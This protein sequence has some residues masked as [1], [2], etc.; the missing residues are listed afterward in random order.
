MDTPLP[1]LPT[2]VV[3]S[4]ARPAWHVVA[5]QHMLAGE[6]GPIDIQ[7]TEDGAVDAAILAQE[8]AGI[9]V[10]TDGEMRRPAGYYRGFYDQFPVRELPPLRR[11]GV[12][13]YDTRPRYELTGRIEPPPH[14]LGL[15]AA[16]EYLRA[17][18]QKPLKATVPG[19]ATFASPLELNGFYAD[20]HAL[21]Y[22]W[23]G[24]I[25]TELRALQAAGATFI[26]L[27]DPA[28]WRVA[29]ESATDAVAVFNRC[30]EGITVKKALH[31]CFGTYQGK[32]GQMR[33]YVPMF[34]AVLDVNVDQLVLEFANREMSE[35]ELWRDFAVEKELGAGVIDCKCYEVETPEDV[36]ARIRRLLA[37]CPPERLWLNPDCGFRGTTGFRT[38]N[39]KLRA[40]ADGAAIVRHELAGTPVPA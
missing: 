5:V 22:E 7:E 18:T 3:G 8:R 10:I 19:P 16:Y 21:A 28:F 33:T 37:Y 13:H 36:A 15:V 12:R 2:S 31:I 1:L 40:L 25:S 23:A 32:P 4:H 35:S 30:F 26:Q 17:H 38:A 39:A 6:F 24:I 9:D 29:T 27:D 14:G 20:R 11:I 34:P